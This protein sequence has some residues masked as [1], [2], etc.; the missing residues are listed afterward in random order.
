MTGPEPTVV[1]A[2]GLVASDASVALPRGIGGAPVEVMR[3]DGFAAVVSELDAGAYGPEV[4][5]AHAEDPRWLEPV[6]REHHEVLQ[7]VVGQAD[8][9]PLR[10]PGIH[11]TRPA[12]AEVLKE[13]GPALAE[14]LSA[15]RGHVELGG[16]VFLVDSRA[17]A[18]T[19]E[20]PRSGREYLARRSAEATD[21]EQS[22]LRRQAK[23]L[24]VHETL[25]HGSTRATVN[26]AQDPALSGRDEPMLLNAAYLVP[27]YDLD[28]FIALAE[29][30]QKDLAPHGM[31]LE[32][33]GPWP[34]YN[35]AD[36]SDGVGAGSRR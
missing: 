31:R 27:R 29:R 20:R 12:L 6:A 11:R 10:L 15:V 17:G 22:R 32:V 8:V 21:R 35:F 3:V 28:G 4:W 14:A 18:E 19:H 25:A 36:L 23:V 13:Q 26:P 1:H 9:L 34:P 30:V 33:T 24:D 7:E 5:R 16:Q 2:Y